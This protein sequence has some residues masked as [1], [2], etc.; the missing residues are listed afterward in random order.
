MAAKPDLNFASQ[1]LPLPRSNS[2]IYTL[3]TLSEPLQRFRSPCYL[4][5]VTANSNKEVCGGWTEP[6]IFRSLDSVSHSSR[7]SLFSSFRLLAHKANAVKRHVGQQHRPAPLIELDNGDNDND[8]NRGVGSPSS[9]RRQKRINNNA[10]EGRLNTEQEQKQELRRPPPTKH[11]V[12]N[13]PAINLNSR[14]RSHL[15]KKCRHPEPCEASFA[16][17]RSQACASA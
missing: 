5:P 14:C 13:A 16:V 7:T 10:T 17:W 12:F 2:H 6:M 11:Y 1:G 9:H 4:E 8:D 3:R 15:H